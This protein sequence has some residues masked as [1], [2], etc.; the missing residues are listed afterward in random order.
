LVCVCW[1]ASEINR[2]E[3]LEVKVLRETIAAAEIEK[4]IVEVRSTH[5]HFDQRSCSV[6]G[7]KAA[8]EGKGGVYPGAEP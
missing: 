4:T 1:G 6:M 7:G 3:D 5:I 2:L 8:C